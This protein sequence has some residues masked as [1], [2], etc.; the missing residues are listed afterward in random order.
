[1][2]VPVL[3]SCGGAFFFFTFGYELWGFGAFASQFTVRPSIFRA[4]LGVMG[5]N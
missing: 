5:T 2:L 3:I 1:M 4:S